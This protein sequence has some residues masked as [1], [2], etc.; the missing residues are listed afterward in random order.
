[1]CGSSPGAMRVLA[2][3]PL[4]VTTSSTTLPSGVVVLTAT[5][6]DVPAPPAPSAP[7]G[8]L[9]ASS[10]GAPQLATTRDSAATRA[11]PEVRMADS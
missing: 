6:V 10:D 7:S 1:M 8:A 2:V 9:G 3:P 11:M 4:Q 5:G